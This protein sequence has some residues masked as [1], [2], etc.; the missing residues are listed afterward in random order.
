M[1]KA[2]GDFIPTPRCNCLE[3]EEQVALKTYLA[4]NEITALI[5]AAPTL[6]DKL[7]I[8]FLADTGCRVS[9]LLELTVQHIDFDQQ[10]VLIPHLKIGIRKKCPKCGNSTGRRQNFCS[11]CGANIS[12]VVADGEEQRTRLLGVGPRTLELCREYIEGRKDDSER[13]IIISRQMV[14]KMLR[15][16]ADQ[17]G[18]SGRVILNPETGRMH[19]VHPHVL[20]SSLA[21]DWLM[22]DDS[23]KGQKALQDQLGHKRY[24]STARYIKLTP[25][26]V[27]KE[28]AKVRRHRFGD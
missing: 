15:Q 13:L 20:R 2:A 19:F 1:V 7:I 8:S 24:E 26:R 3:L 10:L 28:A 25:S 11:K 5:D 4:A 21:V 23:G 12:E 16:C 6:R 17:V 18:L 14:Y 27:K 9:E 22:L